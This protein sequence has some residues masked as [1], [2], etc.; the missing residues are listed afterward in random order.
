MDVVVSHPDANDPTN[1]IVGEVVEFAV[2]EKRKLYAYWNMDP[3]KHDSSLI[4]HIFG[5]GRLH[6]PCNQVDNVGDCGIYI[7]EFERRLRR[8]L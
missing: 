6:V 4:Q 5:L 8:Q 2:K 7:V 1:W 3:K